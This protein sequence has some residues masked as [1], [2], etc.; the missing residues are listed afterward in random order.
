MRASADS[1]RFHDRLQHY[2]NGW[3][4]GCTSP[5]EFARTA[6]R[7]VDDGHTALKLDPFG[8]GHTYLSRY[9]ARG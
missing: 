8:R 5:E 4:T 7:T 6:K 3:F 1:A 9:A 2:T